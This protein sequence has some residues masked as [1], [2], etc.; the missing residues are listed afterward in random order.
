MGSA[1]IDDRAFS[2]AALGTWLVLAVALLLF[3]GWF[4]SLAPLGTWSNRIFGQPVWD[5]H[6]PAGAY[7]DAA[8]QAAFADLDLAD[9]LITSAGTLS[10]ETPPEGNPVPSY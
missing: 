4:S 9:I 7:V 5:E 3:A 8:H 6:D 1:G 10:L 2:R